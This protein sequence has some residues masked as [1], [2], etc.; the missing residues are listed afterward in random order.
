[1]KIPSGRILLLLGATVALAILGACQET[2]PT[3]PPLEPTSIDVQTTEAYYGFETGTCDR[4]L[5]VQ[6]E[7]WYEMPSGAFWRPYNAVLDCSMDSEFTFEPVGWGDGQTITLM[8]PEGA[9]PSSYP[10]YPMVQFT[11]SVPI[12]DGAIPIGGGDP[13]PW[14]AVPIMFSPDIDFDEAVTVIMS[15]PDFAE[16]PEGNGFDLAHITAETHENTTH[17]QVEKVRNGFYYS[18]ESTPPPAA[19]LPWT[20]GIGFQVEHF[21]RWTLVSGD[22]PPGGPGVL[23]YLGVAET[24]HCWTDLPPDPLEPFD[25]LPLFR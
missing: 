17:Y 19:P 18:T 9:V 3:A 22:D 25:A 12:P 24:A 21:S 4:S 1:M 23:D 5:H 20:S 14:T 8:V 13:E 11:V 15:W 10:G 7:E 16:E 2:P 6:L